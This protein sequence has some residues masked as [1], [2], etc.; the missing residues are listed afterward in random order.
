M[1]LLNVTRTAAIRSFAIWFQSLFSW[2]SLLNYVE[3]LIPDFSEVFQSLFSWMSLL[4]FRPLHN[5]MSML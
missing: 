3:A 5:I 2:M 4:N 1:S